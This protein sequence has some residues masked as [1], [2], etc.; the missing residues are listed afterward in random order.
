M[1]EIDEK[2][3]KKVEEYE[4]ELYRKIEN[5]ELTLCEMCEDVF[6]YKPQKRFCDACLKRRRYLRQKD[7]AKRDY[8][9]AKRK[10]SNALSKKQEYDLARRNKWK[11]ENPIQQKLCPACNK[12]FTPKTRN[13]KIKY[14]SAECRNL[15]YKVKKNE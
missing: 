4:D 2:L 5:K 9:V 1:I 12:M 14:C 15:K 7:Y 8:V 6:P 10:T 3:I 11:D 13:P